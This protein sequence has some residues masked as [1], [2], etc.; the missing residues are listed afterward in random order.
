VK[1]PRSPKVVS[2]EPAGSTM[3]YDVT[4]PA[5]R[6]VIVEGMIAH[7][8]NLA[9]LNLVQFLDGAGHFEPRRFAEACRIWTFTLEISVLMAQFPSKIVA[10]KSY[11]F[12]TL[13]LGYAN[14]GTMLMRMGLPYDSEEGFGWCAAISSLHDRR[15]L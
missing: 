2:I 15:C 9:S 4:E 6:S 13:G 1:N 12:R 14:M 7:N 3:V 5:T 10:Q 11:D 8:C